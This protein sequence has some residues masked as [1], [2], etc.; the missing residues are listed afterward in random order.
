VVR[1]IARMVLHSKVLHAVAEDIFPSHCLTQVRTGAEQPQLTIIDFG[2]CALDGQQKLAGERYG[3]MTP[4]IAP[5]LRSGQPPTAACDVFSLGWIA[6]Q[7]VMGLNDFE[8]SC[9]RDSGH[10]VRN[11]LMRLGG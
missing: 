2:A 4:W 6:L 10:P 5:E 11:M 7:C 8:L 9:E 1:L 3:E